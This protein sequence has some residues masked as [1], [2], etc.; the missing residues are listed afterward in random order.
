MIAGQYKIN[1]ETQRFT[2]ANLPQEEF[3]NER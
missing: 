2:L 1:K 3:P